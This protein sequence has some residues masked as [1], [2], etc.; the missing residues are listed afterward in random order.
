MAENEESPLGSKKILENSITGN[1]VVP[2][3]IL[4]VGS[5]IIFGVTK[6][7]STDRSYKDL[8]REMHSKTFGNRWIAAYELSKV[9]SSKGVSE[10]DMPWMVKN[11]SELY[12]TARDPRTRDFIVVALGALKT[13]YAYNILNKAVDDTEPNI[14]FHAVVALSSLPLSQKYDLQKLFK[15][16]D[17]DDKLLKQAAMLTLAT[18]RVETAQQ[19]LVKNLSSKDSYIRNAAATALINF[20]NTAAIS[21]LEKILTLS[22]QNAEGLTIDQLYS[23]KM[24]V[25]G[26]LSKNNWRVLDTIIKKQVESEEDLRVVAIMRE[27]LNQLKN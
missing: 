13:D 18:H 21:Y 14:R 6:L 12:S 4:L 8:V 23:L 27:H 1:L 22:K 3:A 9:I 2:L 25:I 15:F 5:L 19:S 26:A 11:L 20:K 16:L 7:L 24:N 10:E 17:S